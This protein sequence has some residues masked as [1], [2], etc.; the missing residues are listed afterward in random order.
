MINAAI[1][2]LGWWG[3]NLVNSVNTPSSDNNAGDTAPSDAIRFTV[4]HSRHRDTAA[5]FCAETGLT[6]VP[7]FESILA[8]PAI[9]AVVLATPHRMHGT[10]ILRAVAAGKHVFVEKPIALS[11][12]EAR[13]SIQAAEQAGLVL[14][15][16]FN[17]RFHPSM[18]MLREQIRAGRFGTPVSISAE[19]TALHGLTLQPD[20]WRAQPE[21]SPAGAM[22]AIGVHLVDGMIDLFGPIREVTA[23]VARRAS[24]AADD[25]TDIMLR[26]E[27]GASGR[28]VCSTTATPNYR[29]A[30]YGTDAF[31]EITG[32]PM[33]N[34]RLVPASGN[35]Q[36]Q[37]TK[38][39]N[40]L[41]RELDAFA[42]SIESHRPFP[43]P[44]SEILH[45]VA[46]FEAVLRSVQS[47]QTERVAAT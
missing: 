33:E 26:F 22:T 15:V 38:G 17:R 20:A 35:E 40:M 29:M 44:L 24:P 11:I 37:V 23:Q 43:T 46:V 2:G 12:A 31:A 27:N 30:V 41:R 4:G 34:F 47:G 28:I 42:A 9:E 36:V 21:E 45:G 19:Q 10:Q 5:A 32:H 7:D 13:T 39:V 8:D 14:A 3:K 1:V 16:G 25:T 18:A 6:W